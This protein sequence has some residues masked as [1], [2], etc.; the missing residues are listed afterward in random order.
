MADHLP[1]L[2][3]GPTDGFRNEIRDP[4]R[5]A[6]ETLASR[7]AADLSPVS[8]LPISQLSTTRDDSIRNSGFE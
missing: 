2:G 4:R 7:S 6:V 1:G 8:F 3:E 5:P